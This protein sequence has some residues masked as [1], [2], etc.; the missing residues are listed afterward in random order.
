MN[1]V[2]H[3]LLPVIIA[4]I[5]ERSYAE[6]SGRRGIFSPKNLIV[7]GVFGA[8]PDLL[9][10]HLSLAARYVSWSHGVSFLLFLTMV[11]F[12]LGRFGK[13]KFPVHLIASLAGAYAL[14]LFCDAIAGGIAWQYPFGRAVIG[15]YY[16]SPT[17]WI[18][19]DIG[20]ILVC[21]VMFRLMHLRRGVRASRRADSSAT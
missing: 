14:H 12:V 15:A 18:P 13:W 6:K 19:L 10:P 21:Y 16:I 2:T 4:G 20:C 1:T 9:N 8:A 7:I 11:L 17:Y 3:A 5:C